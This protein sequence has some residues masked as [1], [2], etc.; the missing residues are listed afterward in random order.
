MKEEKILRSIDA[1]A[2][3]KKYRQ[4]IDMI[5]KLDRDDVTPA[6][7]CD[8]AKAYRL[9][10]LND[11]EDE[12]EKKKLYERS[13]D[14]LKSV[15]EY[16]PENDYEWNYQIASTYF[17][18]DRKGN[19]LDHFDIVYDLDSENENLKKL[20][21]NCV[22]NISLPLFEHPFAERIKNGWKKFSEGEEKLRHMISN[23]EKGDTIAEYCADLLSD[24][25]TNVSFE[26]GFNGEKYDLILALE[27][28]KY[29][30]YVLDAFR[31]QAPE[32]VKEH[33]NI[34]LGRQPSENT[35][36]GFM[37]KKISPSDV[38]VKVESGENDDCCTVTGYCAELV[39]VLEENEN[40]ALWFF[41]LLLD[42]AVGEIVNMRYV[43]KIDLSDTPFET[44]EGV[45]L[46]EL[47]KVMEEMYGGK[48]GWDSVESYLDSCS[49]YRREPQTDENGQFA[50][51]YDV[52]VGNSSAAFFV[53][54]YYSE[55][56]RVVN[57]AYNDGIALGFIFYPAVEFEKSENKAKAALDF[58]DELERY[59]TENAGEEACKFIGGAS[60]VE[61]GY[62][63]FLAWDLKP[64]LDAAAEFFA[65]KDEIT[66]A[67]YQSFR[68]D[69]KYVLLKTDF[70]EE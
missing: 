67:A 58:R 69:V 48:D 60:G 54:D 35:E 10:A 41:D 25:F 63:D 22:E 2:E 30:L 53:G 55:D 5:D 12:R 37:G 70:E 15:E 47:S 4:I 19:A 16:F 21:A 46:T 28:D 24:A 8:L 34:L 42:M 59:I 39:S 36:L 38:T 56:F 11:E 6:I 26:V 44:G 49:V 7:V 18:L 31:K 33:W 51:R 27:L 66:W 29:T 52:F 32:I 64:V 61:C 65:Q 50:P 45:P 40:D 13:L 43:G 62:L 3:Q 68:S 17:C 14:L 9:S 20:I 23:K 1:L 57:R